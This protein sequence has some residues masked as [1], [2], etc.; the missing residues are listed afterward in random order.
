LIFISAL[1]IGTTIS[2]AFSGFI[3]NE[4]I[5]DPDP[6]NVQDQYAPLRLMSSLQFSQNEI[7]YPIQPEISPLLISKVSQ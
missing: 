7:L 3:L 5:E 1:F 6:D 2:T 4:V